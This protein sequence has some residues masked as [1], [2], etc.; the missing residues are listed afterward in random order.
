MNNDNSRALYD[1]ALKYIPGGVN[2]PVRAFKGVGGNPLF[3]KGGEGPYL[4]D[5]DDNRYVDYVGAWGP[6]IL[7][8]LNSNVVNALKKQ[9][10]AGMGYGASTEGEINIARK[11]CN[12][13]PSI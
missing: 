13:V 5:S 1:L 6:M 7:G 3:F 10:D 9:L 4:I 11:I 8:H 12:L 2:S